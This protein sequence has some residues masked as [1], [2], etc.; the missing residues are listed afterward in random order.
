MLGARSAF[1]CGVGAGI[2]VRG[3]R[4][5]CLGRSMPTLPE[6]RRMRLSL[7]IDTA[8][9]MAR[10]AP[11]AGPCIYGS[12]THRVLV[13]ALRH[14]PQLV[15]LAPGRQERA[16][17]LHALQPH[18]R[19][20]PL[21]C[22]AYPARPRDPPPCGPPLIHIRVRVGHRRTVHFNKPLNKQAAQTC[23][24]G[25]RGAA[26]VL[27]AGAG[28]GVGNCFT[29]AA[30]PACRPTL[31]YSSLAA[32]VS[33]LGRPSKSHRTHD[34]LS[35]RSFGSTSSCRTRQKAGPGRAWQG[36][37]WRDEF[38]LIHGCAH[39]WEWFEPLPTMQDATYTAPP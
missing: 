5:R 16:H 17:L 26:P 29:D 36:L 19:H 37:R 15:Q 21:S 24:H 23:M 7:H 33:R 28:A 1:V 12:G 35:H 10:T 2:K 20:G 32:L 34:H 18:A 27:I 3:P 25:A 30:A 6:A 14:A 8:L 13:L 4:H 9:G 39:A 31:S 11:H 38:Y 22:A